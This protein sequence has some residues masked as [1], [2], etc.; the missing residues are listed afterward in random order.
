MTKTK[1]AKYLPPGLTARN[2][3]KNDLWIAA[4]ALYLDMDLHTLDN[5]FDHLTLFGLVLVKQPI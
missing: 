3:G 5:D 2:M 4:I 1:Q